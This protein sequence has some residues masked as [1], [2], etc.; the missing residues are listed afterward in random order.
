MYRWFLAAALVL[1]ILS[2]FVEKGTFAF[3]TSNTNTSTRF[4]SGSVILSP[5]VATGM[6]LSTSGLLPGNSFSAQ[7]DVR[8]DGD[9]TLR[10]ALAITTTG[11][12]TLAGALKLTIREKTAN[13]CATDETGLQI[14]P[15]PPATAPGNLTSG[16]FG[17]AATGFQAGDRQLGPRGSASDSEALC[18]KIELPSGA[19]GV[20][21]VSTPVTYTFSAEQVLGTSP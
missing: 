3:L 17:S 6:S 2:G 10:Y 21:T 9:L 4:S 16:G 15:P 7:V 12:P 8:N 18:F 13:S 19:T 20:D 1:G 11:D 5:G 14:Y